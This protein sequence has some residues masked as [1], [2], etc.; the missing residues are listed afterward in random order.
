MH[1]DRSVHICGPICKLEGKNIHRGCSDPHREFAARLGGAQCSEMWTWKLKIPSSSGSSASPF[2]PETWCPSHLASGWSS[3]KPGVSVKQQ[4]IWK[5][6]EN[7]CPNIQ[8]HYWPFIP[9]G[10]ESSVFSGSRV[11]QVESVPIRGG[12][13]QGKCGCC[14]QFSRKAM[15]LISLLFPKQKSKIFSPLLLF[16]QIKINYNPNLLINAGWS[17]P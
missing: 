1:A 15:L 10:Q 2:N 14:G 3:H 5:C 7:I 11:S 13:W 17:C 6:C 16:F 12:C 8:G 9:S 4:E